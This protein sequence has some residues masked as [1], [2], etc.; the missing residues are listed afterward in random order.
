VDTV[1]P[2]DEK[3]I[4]LIGKIQTLD[5]HILLGSDYY[6]YEKLVALPRN[7]YQVQIESLLL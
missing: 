5:D 1:V 6:A 7:M 4:Q 3:D 2:P